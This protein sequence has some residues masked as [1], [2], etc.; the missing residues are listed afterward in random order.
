MIG[1]R[2]VEQPGERELGGHRVPT[3]VVEPMQGDRVGRVAVDDP[4]PGVERDDGWHVHADGL[5]AHAEIQPVRAA[6]TERRRSP[7][8]T[9]CSMT[10]PTAWDLSEDQRAI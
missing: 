3:G 9:R 2:G 1:G 5:S 7:C 6:L 10:T 4:V 8:G